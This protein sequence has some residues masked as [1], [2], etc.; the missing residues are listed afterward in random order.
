MPLGRSVV[1]GWV[2]DALQGL[3]LAR[4]RRRYG[5][6]QAAGE[7]LEEEPEPDVR[8]H[9]AARDHG[10]RPHATP[11]Y[12][13]LPSGSKRRRGVN[14]AQ[15]QH[16]H[17]QRPQAVPADAGFVGRDEL[18]VAQRVRQVA[19]GDPQ[20]GEQAVGEAR[21]VAVGRQG[22]QVEPR[23]QEDVPRQPARAAAAVVP[24]ILEDVGH[25]QPL[26]ERHRQPQQ[27]FAVRVDLGG[28][29]AE[30]LGEHL[31]DH[32]GDVV[33]VAIE[34]GQIV[35]AG[36]RRLQLKLRHAVRH[37]PHAARERLALRRFEPVGD[38]DH[39]G[40]VGDQVVLAGRRRGR[41]SR[42]QVARERLNRGPPGDDV[43]EPLGER[44]LLPGGQRGLVFDGVGN[45]A[46][47]VSVAHHIAEP[48]RK[49]RNRE[50]E[51]A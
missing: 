32:A 15:R 20:Q 31:A 44:L 3:V 10:D 19:A 11:R 27:R 6:R 39:A 8:P 4:V 46:Q 26:A 51:G 2:R 28:I 13:D 18:D 17:P 22:A 7:R 45:P 12:L 9:Q 38:A 50:C 21:V 49:L 1:S 30:Q 16:G 47:E 37:D 5:A 35:Q 41:E 40:G 24:Y 14:A 33:A 29:V 23:V 25:L 42:T 48:R 36:G 43:D 34:V